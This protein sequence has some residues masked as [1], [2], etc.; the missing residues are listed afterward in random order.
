MSDKSH[1]KDAHKK[2]KHPTNIQQ[3]KIGVSP[4]K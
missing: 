3:T 2:I 1:Q 4:Y